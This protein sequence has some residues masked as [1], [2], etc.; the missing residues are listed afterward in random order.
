MRSYIPLF[1][2]SPKHG[3][4]LRA[5]RS[6]CCELPSVPDP[7]LRPSY[8]DRNLVIKPDDLRVLFGGVGTQPTAISRRSGSSW[9]TDLKSSPPI[10]N[11]QGDRVVSEALGFGL[12][13]P[14]AYRTAQNG[15]F[16]GVPASW[17]HDH[18]RILC[19]PEFSFD[20]SKGRKT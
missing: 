18:N 19:C 6:P 15:H 4:Q 13:S 3:S 9:A 20:F 5:A 2:C 7:H 16:A 12:P 8:G 14:S 1:E 10:G 17:R 11:R